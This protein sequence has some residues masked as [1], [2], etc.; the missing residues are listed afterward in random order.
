M[1]VAA[2][3]EAN[4]VKRLENYAD[5]YCFL[6]PEEEHATRICRKRNRYWNIKYKLK[7][8]SEESKKLET[9]IGSQV[10]RMEG[11]RKK[12]RRR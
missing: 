7:E 8:D 9:G 6:Y 5:R 4:I 12:L 1:L 2:E 11:P 10:R 3:R